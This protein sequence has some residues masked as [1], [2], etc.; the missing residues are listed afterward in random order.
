MS[1]VGPKI[2]KNRETEFD[3][4][5]NSVRDMSDEYTLE[6]GSLARGDKYSASDVFTITLPDGPEEGDLLH[7][8]THLG[9]M[10]LPIPKGAYEGCRLQAQVTTVHL[11]YRRERVHRRRTDKGFNVNIKILLYCVMIY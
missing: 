4:N 11:Y 10:V 2:D 8:T 6:D 1:A 9:M 5:E 3:L 7:L